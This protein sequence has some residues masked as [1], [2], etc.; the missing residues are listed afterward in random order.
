MKKLYPTKKE[1]VVIFGYK[2]S[3]SGRV[4][5]ILRE[6]TNF[7]IMFFVSVN[8]LQ[9][10]NIEEEH[11]KRPNRKTEFAIDDTIF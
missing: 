9:E 5:N 4:F 11:R 6:Y 1:Q 8:E 2:D 7:E 3:L 10:I